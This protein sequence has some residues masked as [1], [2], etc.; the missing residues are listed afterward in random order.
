MSLLLNCSWERRSDDLKNKKKKIK[1]INKLPEAGPGPCLKVVV[2]DDRDG[3]KEED[4]GHDTSN[5]L[6]TINSVFIFLFKENKKKDRA[7]KN[8]EMTRKLERKKKKKGK[9]Q[10]CHKIITSNVA[11]V[12]L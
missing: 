3:G 5:T 2:V 8:G 12:E 7:E 10:T 6:T 9:R 4:D 1:L 11:A